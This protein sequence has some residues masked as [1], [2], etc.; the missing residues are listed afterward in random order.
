VVYDFVRMV[1][2]KRS[3]SSLSSHGSV[4]QLPDL[5]WK[6]YLILQTTLKAL[7]RASWLWEAKWISGFKI[8]FGTRKTWF[9]IGVLSDLPYLNT[10]HCL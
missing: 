4:L 1:C 9:L 5:R 6:L 3:S 7:L 2:Y 10:N 8:N